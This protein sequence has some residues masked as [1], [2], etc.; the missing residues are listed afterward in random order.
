MTT[1]EFFEVLRLSGPFGVC[2]LLVGFL[3]LRGHLAL[4]RE[5]KERDQRI[6]E[7]TRERDAWQQTALRGTDLLESF[8]EAVLDGRR[9]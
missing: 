6:A 3:L 9:R 5:I 2:A 4:G 1:P 8:K 7:I